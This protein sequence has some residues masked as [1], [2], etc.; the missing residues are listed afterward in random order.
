MRKL[1]EEIQLRE[2]HLFLLFDLCVS[3]WFGARVLSRIRA[4]SGEEPNVEDLERNVP[5]LQ[6]EGRDQE[7]ATD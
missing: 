1:T 3:A 2:V 7:R 4:K 6:D 5:D